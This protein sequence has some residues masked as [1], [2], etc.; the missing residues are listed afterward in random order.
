[1]T[2][3]PPK[4]RTLSIADLTIDDAIQQRVNG[5]DP[6]TVN[7]Y[8]AEYENGNE[9]PPIVVFESAQKFIVADGFHRLAARAARPR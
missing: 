6:A 7:D 5:R 4:T 9:L 3:T 8:A 1:M 2:T